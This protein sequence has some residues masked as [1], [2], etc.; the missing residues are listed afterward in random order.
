MITPHMMAGAYDF[1]CV[2]RPFKGWKLPDS[3]SVEFRV[4]RNLGYYGYFQFNKVP[5]IGVNDEGVG[6]TES[7]LKIVAHEMI[8]MHQYFSRLETKGE[9]HNDNFQK[10]ADR[11]CRLHGW[12]S[13]MFFI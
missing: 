8:H 3:E 5:I 11:V 12:D 7:L 10:L 6:H 2:C 13:K 1:L 9:V 4:I